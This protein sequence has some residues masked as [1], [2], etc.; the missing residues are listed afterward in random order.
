MAFHACQCQL[1]RYQSIA[2]AAGISFDTG[3]L[4]QTCN[5]V[6]NQ[7]ENIFQRDR[8]SMLTL[9]GCAAAKLYHCR[10][11]HCACRAAFCLTAACRPCHAGIRCNND[12]NRRCSKQCHN[13]ILIRNI[14]FLLQCQQCRRKN[15]AAARCRGCYDSAHAGVCLRNRNRLHHCIAEEMTCNILACLQCFI[16]LVGIAACQ[17]AGRTLVLIQPILYGFLHDLQGSLHGCE[18]FFF[19]LFRHCRLCFQN[20]LRKLQASLFR[21][22][23]QFGNRIIF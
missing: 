18:H 11:R 19:C 3:N 5:R 6:A 15:T 1:S 22:V 14:F 9:L 21:F 20:Q 7:T 10:R 17:S 8:T 12:T 4:N 13:Q 16:Q 23:Y 2:Y